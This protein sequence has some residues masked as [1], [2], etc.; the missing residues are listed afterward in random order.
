MDPLPAEFESLIKSFNEKMSGLFAAFLQQMSVG[1]SLQGDVF[2]L[3]GRQ[4][5]HVDLMAGDIVKPLNKDISFDQSLMPVFGYPRA[6]HRGNKASIYSQNLA[7]GK[8][9]YLDYFLE[10]KIVTNEMT[11]SQAFIVDTNLCSLNYR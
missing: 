5:C 4:D 7:I 1:Q 6:D 9:E 3:T 11:L 10:T 8:E 2:A